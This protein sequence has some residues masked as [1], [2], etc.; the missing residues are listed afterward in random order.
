MQTAGS[1]VKWF[2]EKF[3][4]GYGD[5][6]AVPPGANGLLF[7]PYLCGERTPWWNPDARGVFVGMNLASTKEELYRAVLEGVANSLA[8]IRDIFR[9]YVDCGDALRVIGGGARGD[10]LVE[11]LAD[12]C[13]C[14]VE[15]LEGVASATSTGAAVTGG[16]ACG[17]FPDFSVASR[18]AVKADELKPDPARAA[19]YVRRRDLMVEAYRAMEP[20]YGK[21]KD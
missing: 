10:T 9:E 11:L 21:L 4:V 7:L 19:F 2:V 5:A 13:N 20:I 16:V 3:G 15:T 12:A 6:A 8:Y 1:A 17:L 14:R 18:F